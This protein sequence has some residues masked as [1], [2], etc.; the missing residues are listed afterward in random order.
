MWYLATFEWTGDPREAVDLLTPHLEWIREHQ[1]AG[2]MLFAGPSD[3]GE[4]GIIVF[5]HM[6]RTEA[7]TLC[8][9]D[10]FVIDGHRNYTLTGW[11]VH[12]VLGV[13]FQNTPVDRMTRAS[14]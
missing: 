9:N 8:R 10:P 1:L 14:H 7:E 12:Q 3:D 11:D 13:G 4:L 5:G 2:R 6:D